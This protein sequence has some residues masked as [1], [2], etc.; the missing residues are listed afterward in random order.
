M[1][2]IE[3]RKQFESWREENS[4]SRS[5]QKSWL[6]SSLNP[7]SEMNCWHLTS[8]FW[9]LSLNEE[10]MAAGAAP[11]P[12]LRVTHTMSRRH[13]TNSRKFLDPAKSAAAFHVQV[14]LS[15]TL[16]SRVKKLGGS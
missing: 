6:N 5:S 16:D 12:A 3:P 11:R 7:R 10:S 2:T 15:C 8:E 13:C 4:D 1:N 9:I 14:A